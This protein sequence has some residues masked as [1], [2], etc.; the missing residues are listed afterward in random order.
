[1]TAIPN[2]IFVSVK[3]NLRAQTFFLSLTVNLQLN[4]QRAVREFGD[5]LKRSVVITFLNQLDNCSPN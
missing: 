4:F 1:M 3:F 2:F 5:Q